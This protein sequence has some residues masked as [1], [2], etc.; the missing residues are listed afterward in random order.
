MSDQ[1]KHTGAQAHGDTHQLPTQGNSGGQHD[2]ESNKQGDHKAQ[3][4]EQGREHKPNVDPQ[5]ETVDTERTSEHAHTASNDGRKSDTAGKNA[6]DKGRIVAGDHQGGK[7]DA[8][9]VKHG[10][11]S[12]LRG[13]S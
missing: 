3:D 8:E 4:H 7:S 5:K 1:N 13:N 6:P 2:K 9:S 11:K 10:S 12:T